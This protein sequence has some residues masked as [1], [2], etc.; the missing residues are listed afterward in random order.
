MRASKGAPQE[1]ARARGRKAAIGAG[2]VTEGVEAWAQESAPGE[3]V[4]ACGR[5]RMV[6]GV[7]RY[8]IS[9]AER[10]RKYFHTSGKKV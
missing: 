4:L 1:K 6:G 5:K 10:R 2:K 7:G 8:G 9:D 3:Q